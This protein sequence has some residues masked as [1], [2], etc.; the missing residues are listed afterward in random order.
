MTAP[1]RSTDVSFI[2]QSASGTPFAY[3]YTGSSGRGDLNADGSAA[4]DPIYVP[5]D[6]RNP[7]QI[8]FAT[9]SFGGVTYTAEQQAEAFERFIEVHD[10]MRRQR[11][12]IMANTSC[13]NPWTSTL[14]MTIRQTFPEFNNGRLSVQLDIF[15]VPNFIR[16]DWGKIRTAT[17]NTNLALLTHTTSNADG[18][19][20]NFNP[21]LVNERTLFTAVPSAAQFYQMQLSLRYAF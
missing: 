7:A 1:W 20:F 8:Q 21:N 3:S 4:N 16:R 14:D 11:G 17:A 10:C 18:P 12:R 6:A 13:R 15:N 5:T 2:Y 19:V 9:A